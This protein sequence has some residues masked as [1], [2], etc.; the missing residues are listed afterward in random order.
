MMGIQLTLPTE[1]HCTCSA[2][3]GC[4]L[5]GWKVSCTVL[6]KCLLCFFMWNIV[7]CILCMDFA[8]AMHVLLFKNTKRVFP[9][10]GFRLEV[11]LRKFN[12][13]CVI[14]VLFRVLVCSLK[15]RWYKQLTHERTFFRWFREV[16][17]SPLVEWPLA[18]VYHVCRCGELY[19]RKICI[20]NMIKGYNIWNH[21][22]MLSIWICATG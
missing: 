1:L 9:T 16:R 20:L 3:Y 7:T 18:S 4:V 19:M 10:L 2:G 11:Y 14:L 15:G 13:H 21:A 5:N 8:M 17:L 12:R 6:L 22:T